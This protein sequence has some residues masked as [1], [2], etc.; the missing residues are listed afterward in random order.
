MHVTM[1]THFRKRNDAVDPGGPTLGPKW[2]S[3]P[4]PAQLKPSLSQ[5]SSHTFLDDL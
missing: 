5:L 1:E 3:P 4:G 2:A